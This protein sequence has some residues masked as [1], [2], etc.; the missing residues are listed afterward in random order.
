MSEQIQSVLKEARVFP[1]PESF[2]RG[3]HIGSATELEQIRGDAERDPEGF[4]A[5]IAKE[6]HWFTPWE[7]VLEWKPPFAKWF[8][9]GTINLC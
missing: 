7:R 2:S 3:A 8:V 9:G 5:G 4:W 1:P 6:L